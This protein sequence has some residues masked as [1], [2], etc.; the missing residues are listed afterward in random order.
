MAVS[1]ARPCM[2]VGNGNCLSVLLGMEE[3]LIM[4]E[5]AHEKHT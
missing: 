4:L 5:S 2:K 1:G 3:P